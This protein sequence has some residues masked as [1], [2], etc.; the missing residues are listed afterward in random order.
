MLLTLVLAGCLVLLLAI[1]A[2]AQLRHAAQEA[3]RT[4]TVRMQQLSAMAAL[5]LN[6]SQTSLLLHQ[7]LLAPN[8]DQRAPLLHAIQ[9]QRQQYYDQAQAYEQR[10]YHPTVQ[11]QYASLPAL[12]LAF[13]QQVEAQLSQIENLPRLSSYTTPPPNELAQRFG[14]VSQLLTEDVA[15]KSAPLVAGLHQAVAVQQGLLQQEIGSLADELRQASYV[16][17]LCLC[18]LILSQAAASAALY[19][20]LNAALPSQPEA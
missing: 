4:Q 20:K 10:I 15:P 9:T 3:Q 12:G 8:D 7:A 16:L 11:A 2:Y 1:Y 18:F 19:R 5:E 17:L 6:V 14:Q 13:W